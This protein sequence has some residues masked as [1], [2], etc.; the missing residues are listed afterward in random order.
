MNLAYTLLKDFWNTA[1]ITWIS[2]VLFEFARP[3]AV[4]RFIN[5]EYWFYLLIFLYILIRILRK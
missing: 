4:Q 5:L 3:G 2:L 1:L